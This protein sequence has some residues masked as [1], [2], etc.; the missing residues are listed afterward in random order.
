MKCRRH[1]WRPRFS[2]TVEGLGGN[3]RPFERDKDHRKTL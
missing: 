1:H 3:A 2:L